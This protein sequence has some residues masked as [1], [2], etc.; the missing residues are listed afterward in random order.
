MGIFYD[1]VPLDI[2]AFNS[3]P[4]QRITT[5]GTDGLPV[6]PPVFYVNL[7]D[8]AVQSKFPF[9]DRKSKTGNFAPYSTAASAICGAATIHDDARG[10]LLPDRAQLAETATEVA[11]AVARAAVA[12]A[13]HRGS[14]RRD[15]R[16]RAAHPLAGQVP[17][18]A[19]G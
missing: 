12:A 10:M 18:G 13:W 9:I 17:V 2:Y 4:S 7:T 1:S 6:G 8:Q 11:R 15:R 19:A 16:R 5:Y 3:Y 14:P